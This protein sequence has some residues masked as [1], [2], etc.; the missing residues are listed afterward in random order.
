M[1]AFAREI[2]KAFEN[3]LKRN[4]TARSLLSRFDKITSWTH[5]VSHRMALDGASDSLVQ[6]YIY[7][8]SFM[9]NQFV[10]CGRNCWC[11]SMILEVI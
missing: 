10:H 9:R 7:Q 6:N 5:C 2:A 8:I 1:K 3:I 4:P 11:F